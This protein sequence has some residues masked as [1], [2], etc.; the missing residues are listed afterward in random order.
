MTTHESQIWERA[1]D[2]LWVDQNLR[3][4]VP[5]YL[6]TTDSSLID[7]RR[8]YSNIKTLDAQVG[9]ILNQLEEDGL[10]EETIVVFYSDHGGP[11]PRQKRLLYDSGLRVPMIIRFPHKEKAGTRDPQMVSFIDFAP[12]TLSL[13]GIPIPVEMDGK[14]FLGD[15][16]ATSPRQYIHAAADRFDESYDAIRAVRDMRYKYIQYLRPELPMFL[17]VGY[18]DQMPI[19]RELYRLRDNGTLDESQAQWFRETKPTEE[20]FDTEADP[21]E[22]HNIAMD[23]DMQIKLAELKAE[24]NR[25]IEE[26]EDLNRQPELVMI[27]RFWPEG[28]QPSTAAVQIDET[29][30][31]VILSCPTLGASIAYREI[32]GQDTSPVWQVFHQPIRGNI[33]GLVTKAQRIGYLPSDVQTFNLSHIQ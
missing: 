22:L 14:A 18:R 25:W 24:L 15:A 33:Q 16:R 19:M 8:L 26:K 31:G 10:L 12:T 4:P 3:V 17:H 5:P 30:E 21:Y 1:K 20:L 6:P 32:R 13:A 7:I 23:P 2:S 28:V 27:D 11:L 29:K 9:D